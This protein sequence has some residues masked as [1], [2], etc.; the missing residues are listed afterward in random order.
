MNTNP[1][2]EKYDATV[3]RV[4]H[5]D[6][7]DHSNKPDYD[8]AFEIKLNV[9]VHPQSMAN[10]IIV[11][12]PGANGDI[13]GYN[14]K[15]DV[16]AKMLHDKGYAVIQMGNAQRGWF[17]YERSVIEDLRAVIQ[18]AVQNAKLIS[19]NDKP[20]IYL[21][22]FSAGASAVAA[23]CADF[24]QVKKV[25]LMAPSGDANQAA[26]TQSLANFGG[27]VYIVVGEDDEVVGKGAAAFFS[28]LIKRATVNEV[29]IIPNCDHQF[30][31]TVNGQIMS[32]A[33]LW[34]FAGDT[35]F[36]SPEGGIML[37]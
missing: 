29:R 28:N 11:N 32:K 22:G 21:M 8:K 20:D 24:P 36:P 31:G 18:H 16:V 13:S 5:F 23:V 6:D 25:L 33:P 9:I 30:R 10:A 19:G 37:Y 15:Y 34:A 12:Y 2:S 14:N 4:D 27:E 1:N 35:T 17:L 7:P 3:T 26:V